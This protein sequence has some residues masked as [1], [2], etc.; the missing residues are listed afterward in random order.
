M[1]TA[2]RV[3]ADDID[4]NESHVVRDHF[5]GEGESK[6]QVNLLIPEFKPFDGVER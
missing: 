4:L 2:Q 3:V 1:I 6:S 5:P